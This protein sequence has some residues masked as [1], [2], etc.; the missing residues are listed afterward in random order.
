MIRR[1]EKDDEYMPVASLVSK[2]ASHMYAEFR[3]L[4]KL[5]TPEES[6]GAFYIRNCL[7]LHNTLEKKT[8]VLKKIHKSSD[9]YDEL[10]FVL[11]S[12]R[13]SHRIHQGEIAVLMGVSQSTISKFEAGSLD[14]RIDFLLLYANLFGYEINVRSAGRETE[15]SRFKERQHKISEELSDVTL[16]QIEG[17]NYSRVHSETKWPAEIAQRNKSSIISDLWIAKHT[18]NHANH[19]INR[20]N[21]LNDMRYRSQMAAKILKMG[22]SSQEESEMPEKD[23]QHSEVNDSPK[24]DP[25]VYLDE[26]E[27]MTPEIMSKKLGVSERTLRRFEREK[28]YMPPASMVFKYASLVNAELQLEAYDRA[29]HLN[30]SHGDYYLRRSLALY[31]WIGNPPGVKQA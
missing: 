30:E 21:K 4:E 5:Q 22:F 15:L 3:L 2:Y 8:D 1:F 25:P 13:E 23:V 7:A 26:V 28:G 12:I 16:Q 6:I 29:Y 14:V 10:V 20:I 17:K 19:E 18:H 11:R 9:K 31:D 24:P 27:E